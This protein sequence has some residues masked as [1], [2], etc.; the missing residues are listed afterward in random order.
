MLEY[1]YGNRDVW[2][3]TDIYL[4][5]NSIKIDLEQEQRIDCCRCHRKGHFIQMD[6]GAKFN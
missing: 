5:K 6:N 4:N 2:K 1:R 3:K